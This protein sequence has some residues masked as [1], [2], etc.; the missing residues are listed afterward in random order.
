MS[1]FRRAFSHGE[2]VI[3][4]M[5][6][7]ATRMVS[8]SYFKEEGSADP[9][10][11]VGSPRTGSTILYQA[12]TNA[13][14]VA[15]IDNLACRWHWNLRFGIWLSHREYGQTPHNNFHADLGSTRMFGG[16]APSECGGFWYRWL[17]KKRHFVDYQDIN[18]KMVEGIRSEILG[19]SAFLKKP[20]LFKNLNAGQRLRLIRQAFPEA[21]ILFIRRD[22]RFVIRSILK[23]RQKAVAVDGEWWSIMPPNV[24]E[25]KQLPEKKMCAAQVYYLEKQIEEDLTLFEPGNIRE[26]HYQELS[27]SLM[28]ALA[29][30]MG[31]GPRVGGSLPVFHQDSI[32]DLSNNEL[33][34]LNRIVSDFPFRKDLLI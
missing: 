12:L 13:Y 27:E 33:K 18:S 14:D 30:W 8:D 23:A 34:E 17:S 6:A 22:P 5:L 7:H 28:R 4:S 24:E 29:D 9:I 10:F 26:I 16:H 25:L 11:I 32:E 1:P 3:F 2:R 31:V 20:M 19:A 15:Y 21:K